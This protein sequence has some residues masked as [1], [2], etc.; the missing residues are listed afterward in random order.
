MWFHVHVAN[1]T[2]I[3]LK[4]INKGPLYMTSNNSYS[5]Y[6]RPPCQHRVKVIHH[7][8]P[9]NTCFPFISRIKLNCHKIWTWRNFDFSRCLNDFSVDADLFV[10]FD[11]W[12]GR[13]VVALRH[14]ANELGPDLDFT[15]EMLT[16]YLEA[17]S[18]FDINSFRFKTIIF[19]SAAI[20]QI[21]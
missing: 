10:F 1:E 9:Q 3:T 19:I 12:K 7:E 20:N 15:W 4:I 18:K 16:K 17:L 21:I 8:L 11:E 14:S 2:P 13:Q 5:K 6:Q